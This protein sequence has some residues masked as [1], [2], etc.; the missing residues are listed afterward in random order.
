MKFHGMIGFMTTTETSPGVWT[1]DIIEKPYS[2]DVLEIS[3]RFQETEH[4]NDDLRISN[5]ISILADAFASE[6][7]YAI[8]Y[9]VWRGVKWK[10]NEVSVGFPSLTLSIG[11]L[12]N[13]EN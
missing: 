6:N 10:V 11:G 5:R 3:R 12:Y 13:A 7:F 4:I 8:T 9:I 2:G 1:E